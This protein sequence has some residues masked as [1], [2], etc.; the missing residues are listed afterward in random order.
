MWVYVPLSGSFGNADALIEARGLQSQP[1]FLRPD[2][3]SIPLPRTTSAI[4][5]LVDLGVATR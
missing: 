3:H 2:S 1:K 5:A 4:K